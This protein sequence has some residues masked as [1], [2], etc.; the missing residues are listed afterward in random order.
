MKQLVKLN[1]LKLEMNKYLLV[2]VFF[3]CIFTIS[4]TESD[5]EIKSPS[6]KLEVKISENQ[7]DLILSLYDS[8]IPILT[9]NVGSFVFEKNDSLKFDRISEV[10]QTLFDEEWNPVYGERNVVR[11]RYNQLELTLTAGSLAN[12]ELKLLCRLYD[13]GMAFRYLFDEKNISDQLLTKELTAFNFDSDYETWVSEYAQGVYKKEN[14]SKIDVVCER[15]LVVKKNANSFLA[16]G[17]A[18]LVDFARMKFKRD[19]INSLSLQVDLS[20]K[21]DIKK[22]KYITPWRYVMVGK[23]PCELLENNHFIENLNEPNK[24]ED[25][26]WIKPGKVIREVTLTTKG[27]LACVDFAAKHNLQYVEFDA[28]WYGNEYDDASDATTVTVDPNRSPGPLDLHQV[29]DYAKQKGIG[30]I[31][32]VNRRA[33]EKQLDEILPLY[34]SWGIKGLKYGFVNVGPQEWTLWLHDA[35]RKAAEYELMVDV[36]DEYRPTGYSRTY[37]NLI[38]QEG[39]LGDELSP[40][41]EHTLITLFTRMIAGAADNTNSFLATRVSEKMG[42]KAGQMAKAVML[43]SPWQF[44]Y[45]YDRPE[46]SPVKKGGAGDT[47]S[48]IHESTE[49]AFYDALPTVWDETKVLEGEIGEYATIARKN[50]D[51]WFVGSLTSN[52]TRK[53]EIPLSFLDENENYEAK[54]FSQNVADLKENK[55]SIETM[56]VNSETILSRDLVENSGFTIIIRKI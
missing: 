29:I 42:G 5:L 52:Q 44:V 37:P 2:S 46:G 6:E 17:E 11:N 19:S 34:K 40:S 8:K 36:H 49:L 12:Q 56:D 3:L 24:L 23:S 14:I 21:V 48:V 45:W 18:A 4:C 22:A 26:S 50:G 15:P 28:G 53:V 16:I 7:S 47:E 41:T 30:I 27:G 25:V 43:Y 10:K 54:V 31:L 39:I 1:Q 32:Y 51:T 38:S 20:S 33:L 9:V 35:V 13:E 55:V